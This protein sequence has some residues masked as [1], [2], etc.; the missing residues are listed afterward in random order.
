[1]NPAISRKKIPVGLLVATAIFSGLLHAEVKPNPLFTD[2]AVL[3]RGQSV[4]V[5][6]TA[7]DGE[8]V[9]VEFGGQKLETTAKDGKWRVDLKPLE[10]GG[11]FRMKISGENTVEVKDLLVGEVWVASGQ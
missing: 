8:K 5:W 1:M 2:G 10:A 9:S 6:G 11:P 3:Q 4:P 7:K